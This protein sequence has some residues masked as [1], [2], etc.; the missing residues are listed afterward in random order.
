MNILGKGL[1]KVRSKSQ[2][3]QRDL[4]GKIGLNDSFFTKARGS[5]IIIY[6]G[7]C[8]DDHLRF[9]NIFLTLSMFEEHLK[10]YKQ[11]FNVVSLD[12]YYDQRFSDNK[13]NVCLTFD[14]GFANNYKHVLP[15]LE[16]YQLPATFFITG[17]RDAGY[18]ILWNDFLGIISRYGPIRLKYGGQD[19]AKNKWNKY[20]SLATGKSLNDHIREGGFEAKEEMIEKLSGL[21]PYHENKMEED[22]WL[23]MTT[24]EIRL[25][26]QSKL[27]TI[28][29][30]GY[31]HNDLAKIPVSDALAEM[32]ESKRFLENIIGQDVK[33][34]AFPYGTYTRDVVAAAKSAGYSQLLAMDYFF[35][36]DAS[37]TTM[38]ERF[39]VNPFISPT[40]QMFANVLGK[41]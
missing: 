8:N 17:I 16:Q 9:N 27:A 10:F 24:E 22:Y 14:D 13:Y 33:A 5:R 36:E 11:H 26:S 12:D 18:D 38:R 35:P 34:M 41:Y 7:V 31:Y 21:V 28:G 19:Y 39:T 2:N 37:D 15:L 20:I 23:Q 6:H 4:L 25:L 1:K 3:W 29:A 40:N 30:H 32:S